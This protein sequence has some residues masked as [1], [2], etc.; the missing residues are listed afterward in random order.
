MPVWEINER[1]RA[2][3]FTFVRLRY[4]SSGYR[5]GGGGWK[6][7]YPGADLNF[8]FRLQQLTS[9]KVD[10]EALDLDITDPK[11]FHYPFVF[12]NDPRSVVF[13]DEEAAALRKYLLSGGFL[14]VDDFWGDQMWNHLMDE[15][16]KVLP[17]REPVSLPLTHP[18]FNIP[19]PLK[20][21][22]QVPSEDSA[23]DM[24]NAPD[25]YRTWEYEFPNLEPQPADYR[26]FLDDK[27]RIMMLIC[28]N[29]DLS[30]GWEE[31]GISEW[32]F[33]NFAEKFA[34]PMGINIVFHAL[35]H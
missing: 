5:R 4:N 7:D 12:M 23:H 25:P 20:E 17:G 6:N 31:E 35:T 28:W 13:S 16:K 19:Y 15:M 8:S 34:Y 22:P 33:T 18:I 11:L 2:D 14:M 21:K 1:F 29:T 3:I 24:A 32:F 27:G 9:M 30:D 26:A 10:P